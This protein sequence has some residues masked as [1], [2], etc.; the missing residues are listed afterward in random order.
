LTNVTIQYAL[1]LANKGLKRA[2]EESE[3]LRKGLNTYAGN[4]T[5]PA[6]ADAHKI[7]FTPYR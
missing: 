3:P 7:K 4:L 2:L 6:V 5:H 1:E